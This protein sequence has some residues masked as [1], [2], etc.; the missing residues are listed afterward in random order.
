MSAE[1]LVSLGRAVYLNFGEFSGRVAVITDIIDGKRVIVAN[2]GAGIRHH[3]VSNKR[4]SLTRFVVPHVAPTMAARDLQ[5]AIEAYKLN[6]KFN[7]SGLGKRIQK[8][9]RRAQLTDFERFK[10]QVLKKKL[11]KTLRTHINK[12]RKALIAKAK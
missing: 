4:I 12:N 7:A 1:I 10:V 6:D 5:K 3:A 8:Q 2:P 9:N 11:S